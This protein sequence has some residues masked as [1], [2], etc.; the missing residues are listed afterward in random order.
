MVGVNQLDEV[1][2]KDGKTSS[3]NAS[4]YL[5]VAIQLASPIGRRFSSL[6]FMMTP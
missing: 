4:S 5:H 3:C 1:R 2:V 6:N